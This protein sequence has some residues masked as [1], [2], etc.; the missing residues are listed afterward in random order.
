[1]PALLCVAA[2]PDDE[3]F[4]PAG[5]IARYAAAGIPVDLLTFTRGQRGT[6]STAADTPEE[7]GLLREYE[8]RASALVLDIRT[9]T[10]LDYMDG[11]LDKIDVD[12]LAEHIVGSIESGNIDAL[13]T[14]GPI[15]I[16]RHADH[17]AVHHATM[18]AV[19]RCRRDPSVFYQAVAD[20]WA[21]EMNITGPEAEPT[22]HIDISAFFE[23]K[24]AALACHSSQEDSRQFFAMLAQARPQVEWFHRAQPPYSEREPA[25]D[26][27]A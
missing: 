23:T 5:T 16:T 22:H 25:T 13:I 8:T 1:M 7:L 15:G 27:F 11:E 2:H 4:G 24:L 17:I 3:A 20:P 10:I 12:E 21:K 19:G 9:L 6:M 14:M 18:R 26:L